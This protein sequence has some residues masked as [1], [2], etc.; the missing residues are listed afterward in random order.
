MERKAPRSLQKSQ[1]SIHKCNL[2]R[3][4]LLKLRELQDLSWAG[5]EIH[6]QGLVRM[7]PL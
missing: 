2:L 4:W 7:F 6:N 3:I 1:G 5:H